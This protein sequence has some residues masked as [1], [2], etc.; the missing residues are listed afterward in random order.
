VTLGDYLLASLTLGW[1]IAGN[2]EAFAR[3]ENGFDADY[4]DAVGYETQ[5]RT[6]HAGLRI[7]FGD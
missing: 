1:R 3:A 7:R 6:V 5:G 2:V 4:Q